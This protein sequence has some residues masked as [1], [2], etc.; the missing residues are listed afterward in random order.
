M[1]ILHIGLP[2]TASTFLQYKIFKPAFGEGFLHWKTPASKQALL[3]FRDLSHSQTFRHH[4]DYPEVLEFCK[5]VTEAGPVMVTDE[6]LAFSATGF[7]QGLGASPAEFARFL[8]E[9]TEDIGHATDGLR[10]LLGVRQHESWLASIYA[11][12]ASQN[13]ASPQPKSGFGTA[14]FESRV[15]DVIHEC[16]SIPVYTWLRLAETHFALADCLG[17]ENVLVYSMEDLTRDPEKQISRIEAFCGRNLLTHLQNARSAEDD[18]FLNQLS[19]GENCWEMPA[20]EP[21]LSIATGLRD[22]IRTA[23]A[24]DVAG[25]QASTG[26]GFD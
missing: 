3:S 24:P 12:A 6:T 13:A 2:K 17:P 4:P 8:A 18:F 10:V 5:G 19:I 26:V 14:D 25:L 9:L 20:G 21:P 16:D 1:L 7:W 23:F 15:L 11:H 22:R